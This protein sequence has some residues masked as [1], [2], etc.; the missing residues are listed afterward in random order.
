MDQTLKVCNLTCSKTFVAA[1]FTVPEGLE[2]KCEKCGDNCSTCEG[3]SPYSS[4]TTCINGYYYYASDK[5]CSLDC[6]TGWYKNDSNPKT[7]VDKCSDNCKEC[8]NYINNCT[9]CNNIT[10]L[11]F[12]QNGVCKEECFPGFYPGTSNICT[13]CPG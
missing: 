4:C 2:G 7:C 5:A 10:A 1:N 6:P 11:K 8:S 13:L 3:T 9:I 12:L